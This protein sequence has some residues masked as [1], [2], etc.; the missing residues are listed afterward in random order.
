MST[1]SIIIIGNEILSGKFPDENT[2][3]LIH[4]LK[5]LGIQLARAVVIPDVLEEIEREVAWSSD[6]Y[7]YVVT[8][9]GV[10]P[11]HDDMTMEGVAR[12]FEV[13]LVENLSLATLIREKMSR[14][15]AAALRMALVPEGSR[16][17]EDTDLWF[18]LVVKENVHILPGVPGLMRRKFE[19][20]ARLWVGRD[21]FSAKVVSSEYETAIA[22]RLEQA[23]ARWPRVEIG[24]YP[25]YEDG[26]RHVIV[27]M[28]GESEAEVEA[29][30]GWLS[31]ALTLYVPASQREP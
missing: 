25:R 6:R 9:G 14:A 26:P 29:C 31:G 15:N 13:D 5:A 22:D 24:S 2:P 1:S 18:P 12:A 11:T 28:E 21:L 19:S 10:G 8:T 30:R 4:R 7:D 3:F 23:V 17:V 16:L 20:A 27:T